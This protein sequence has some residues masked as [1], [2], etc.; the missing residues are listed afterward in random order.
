MNS[1]TAPTLK[2]FLVEDNE[3]LRGELTSTLKE[4]ANVD[5]IGFAVEEAQAGLW[6][7]G[8][9]ASC[10]LVIIDI[11]LKTGSGLGV[12]RSASVMHWPLQ[13][14]VLSNYAT[15]DMR[16]RCLDHGADRVF[17]K[18]IEIELLMECCRAI[19]L[20]LPSRDST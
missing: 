11:F 19:P 16:E 15:T 8:H 4:L 5:V 13:L 7:R 17:D 18:S 10:D 2:A 6:L 3:L 12:L 14:I 1:C 20:R 9:H